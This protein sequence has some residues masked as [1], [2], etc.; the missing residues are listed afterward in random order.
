MTR[1][2]HR[3]RTSIDESQSRAIFGWASL[4]AFAGASLGIVSGHTIAWFVPITFVI[5]GI[6]ALM[7]LTVSATPVS[8]KGWW[9]RPFALSKRTHDLLTTRKGG[10]ILG[11][12]LAVAMIATST[13]VG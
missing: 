11:A 1:H 3:S 7:T 5:G 6:M 9:M 4:A 13:L 8:T 2:R 12:V 10:L